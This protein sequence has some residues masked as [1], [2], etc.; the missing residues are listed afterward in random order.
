M[1]NKQPKPKI[2]AVISDDLGVF[3]VP[4]DAHSWFA[5]ASAR[6]IRSLLHSGC[7]GCTEADDLAIYCKET[8]VLS[9]CVFDLCALVNA[10][11]RAPFNRLQ[12]GGTGYRVEV[13]EPSARAWL[14]KHRPEVL[15]H[16]EVA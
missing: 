6:D 1:A 14:K 8:A 9:P 3:I 13:D 7:S 15:L 2:P 5:Q 11:E 10:R 4:F 12:N 16:L